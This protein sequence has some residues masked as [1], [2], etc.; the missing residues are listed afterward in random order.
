M[1]A[2]WG[3]FSVP[4]GT[5]TRWRV[6]PLSLF[7]ERTEHDW[8]IGTSKVDQPDLDTIEGPSETST[9]DLEALT[10][11][12]RIG[13]GGYDEGIRIEPC[14]ADRPV[15]AR[16]D[17]PFLVAAGSAVTIY[18]GTPL[19]LRVTSGDDSHATLREL[20]IVRPSDTWHGPTTD[21]GELCYASRT[22]CRTRLEDVRRLPHRAV[23][24]VRI[25][26][27]AERVLAFER[28]SIPANRLALF[29]GE[30]GRIWTESVD[31][32][33]K[34]DTEFADLSIADGPPASM[35]DAN[36]LAAPRAPHEN[37]VVRAFAAL[38]R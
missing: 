17:R 19:W 33:R 22:F 7:V 25:D 24:E 38:I 37:V 15:V 18:V 36:L 14:Q 34:D 31:F 2:W 23:T 13:V 32:E 12:E 30:D 1:A 4:V 35:P 21:G 6:G 10:D 28:I 8:R 9:E 16:P 29:W 27:R 5:A 20:P 11:L 3:D 26:N